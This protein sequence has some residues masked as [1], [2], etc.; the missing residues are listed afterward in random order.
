[1][2]RNCL[3]GMA[4]AVWFI[5]LSG[6]ATGLD[7]IGVNLLRSVTT[8]LDGA[9]IRVA[10][11]EASAPT[12]EVDPAA[13]G[14]PEFLFTYRSAAGEASNYPNS[15]GT[16]SDHAGW[17]GATFYG[18]PGGVATNVAHV[19]S[20]DA[21][22][23]ITNYV[24]TLA[25]M[26]P[27][28]VVNQSFTFGVL[29]VPDQQGVDSAYDD[30]AD[31]FA[32]CF[33]SAACNSNISFQVC[34]PGTAYNCISVGAYYSG[35][36]YNSIGPT[37][38]NGRCKPDI[39]AIS[40][41]T[42]FS[43]PQV[44]GAVALLQQAALRGDGGSDT[45]AAF[46]LRTIKALLLNG[47]VKPLGWTNSAAAPLDYR[48][49]AGVV[50]VFNAYEQLTGGEHP[51]D[52]AGPIGALSGWNF[53]S[54]ASDAMNDATNRYLFDVADG[55]AT[56]TLVWNR[57]LGQTNINDL[58]LF[59]CNS[60]GQPVRC[61]TSRVDNVEHIFVPRLPAGRYELRV[62]K[63][64]GTNVVSEAESYALAWAF[65]SPTLALVAVGGE[66]ELSWPLY[67]A[68]FGVEAAATLTA[69]LWGTN[70]LPASV[71]T[72]SRN[73]LW[74]KATNAVQFFR[75]RQPNL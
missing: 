44:A 34:A 49:G 23:F 37:L 15:V 19:D 28:S 72:N 42:S 30:Y 13:T 74:L 8:N 64:G 10:Q 2:M 31:L 25:P 55:G 12:F 20:Y 60:G 53:T 43:T 32:T 70:H 4:L 11:P 17:V 22:F 1:M 59:L 40:S 46:D 52:A 54:L 66:V 21:D 6:R 33:V 29:A 67:P 18:R 51:A 26:P 41:A 3:P 45:N 14:Q 48:H 68:G 58:D 73:S 61:S 35:G 9:G 71:V 27:A 56:A 16:N 75:L 24:D 36:Y 39:T 62:V 38:D 69:P 5:C 65:G 57:Q 63:N 50:N 7:D 47:A